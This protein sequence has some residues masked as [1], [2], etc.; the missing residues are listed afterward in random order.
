MLKEWT[1]RGKEKKGY[2]FM[3]ETESC[4]NHAKKTGTAARRCVPNI[5]CLLDPATVKL[6]E[7]SNGRVHPVALSGR[8]L[9]V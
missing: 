4:Q 8:G 6:I 3:E 5:P 1:Y 9:N 7:V 2:G